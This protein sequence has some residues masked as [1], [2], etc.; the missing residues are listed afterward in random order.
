MS[1]K[2]RNSLKRNFYLRDERDLLDKQIAL[3][4]ENNYP[5]EEIQA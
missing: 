1:D 5:P 2:L 3:L 4:K